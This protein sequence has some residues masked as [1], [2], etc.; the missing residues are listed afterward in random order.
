M[1]TIFALETDSGWIHEI[2]ELLNPANAE[3]RTFSDGPQFLSALDETLP[4]LILINLDLE[5]VDGGVIAAFLHINDR[6]SAIPLVTLSAVRPEQEIRQNR[7]LNDIPFFKKPLA[8]SKL[9]DLLALHLGS[10]AVREDAP[11]Y[12]FDK[13]FDDIFKEIGSEGGEARMRED[14][15]YRITVNLSKSQLGGDPA[16]APAGPPVAEAVPPPAPEI[17][18][19]PTPAAVD[20]LGPLRDTLAE[21]Q[22][23]LEAREQEATTMQERLDE[24]QRRVEEQQRQCQA[25]EG[26]NQ[27]WRGQVEAQQH[28][29]QSA[30]EYIRS[31]QEELEQ[32]RHLSQ[33]RVAELLSQIGESVGREHMLSEDMQRLQNEIQAER[34]DREEQRRRAEETENRLAEVQRQSDDWQEQ[35]AQAG[36]RISGLEEENGRKER[37]ATELRAA[38][39][40]GEKAR[41]EWESRFRVEEAEHAAHRAEMQL[42]LDTL[43]ISLT[44]AEQENREL[45]E[46][47]N[48]SI[49][50]LQ[51]E[52]RHLQ[53]QRQADTEK[54]SRLGVQL[55]ESLAL[56]EQNEHISDNIE[57][58]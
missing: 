57:F 16:A 4:A 26:E 7:Q 50:R 10:T 36:L 52:I 40:A 14:S 43:R 19:P 30:D 38:L 58:Q 5:N 34:L 49:Q 37:Q 48:Q 46:T 9:V 31:L 32:E 53:E 2:N 42:Q 1:K 8:T 15:G 20:E 12:S 18:P 21:T 17:P 24:L 23:R 44:T 11:S 41:Q 22:R 55:R 6:T 45:Q 39:E 27:Q 29:R 25:L 54:L 56:L 33:Q 3:L 28:S 35:L 13:F 47:F 51:N